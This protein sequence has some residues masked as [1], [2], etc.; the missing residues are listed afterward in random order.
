M[1]N[2][3]TTLNGALSELGETLATNI[4]SKGV[5][6][7]ASDGLTTLANKVLQITGGG[8][9]TTL[10]E[11]DCSSASG[12]TNYGSSECIRGSNASFTMTYNA[13][14]NAYECNGSGNYHAYIPIPALK[15]ED[16]YTIEAEFKTKNVQYN[17]IGFYLDNYGD[18][19]SYGQSIYLTCYSHDFIRRL[20]NMSSDGSYNAMRNNN[21]LCDTWYRI[22]MTVDGDNFS[23]KL[24]DM[25]GNLMNSDTTT[26]S[27]SNKSMGIL[28]FCERGLSNSICYV[29]NIKAESLG[30]GSDCSQYTTQISNAI[31]YINGSGS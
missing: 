11:D 1:T 26:Y 4:T 18:T 25:Q 20:Y 13:T 9:S 27:I 29:R 21:I 8:G 7:S 19:T 17:A 12:L 2:D 22:S 15:D 28:L 30:G 16:N 10:F 6:A 31:E 5:S 24:Y 14:E 3:T 23:F